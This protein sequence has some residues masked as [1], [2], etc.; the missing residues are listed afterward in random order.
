M[1]FFAEVVFHELP[2]VRPCLFFAELPVT[3][4][5]DRRT[6]DNDDVPFNEVVSNHE[7]HIAVLSFAS[8]NVPE[9]EFSSTIILNRCHRFQVL[10]MSTPVSVP[11]RGASKCP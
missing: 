5:Q 2:S 8:F 1:F 9:H 10:S 4:N 7:G 6:L 3:L 11:T